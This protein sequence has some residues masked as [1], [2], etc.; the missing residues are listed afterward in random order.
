MHFNSSMH[1]FPGRGE[2]K[3]K[4]PTLDIWHMSR[5]NILCSYYIYPKTR[6]AYYLHFWPGLLQETHQEDL[7]TRSY[8][9]ELLISLSISPTLNSI[10]KSSRHTS[11]KQCWWR[12]S[13][14]MTILQGINNCCKNYRDAHVFMTCT[15]SS[16]FHAYQVHLFNSQ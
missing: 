9:N 8:T 14:I 13:I 1:H 11:V 2:E 4:K 6:V 7:I 12:T 16:K 5:Q 15:W 3:K 10:A